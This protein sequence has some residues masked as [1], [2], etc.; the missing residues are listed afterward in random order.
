MQMAVLMIVRVAIGMVV[1]DVAMAM[2]MAVR[3]RMRVG[4]PMLMRMAVGM[5]MAVT[6][7]V[8]GHWSLRD[9]RSSQSVLLLLGLILPINRTAAA[10]GAVRQV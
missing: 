5:V 3:V 4:V 10:S 2:G 1:R 6:V 9:V 7:L 8:F